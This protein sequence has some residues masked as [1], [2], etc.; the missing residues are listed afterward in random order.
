[1]KHCGVVT[2]RK[3]G[4][5]TPTEFPIFNPEYK[6]QQRRIYSDELPMAN[7]RVI[8]GSLSTFYDKPG[9]KLWNRL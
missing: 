1:M 9:V 6:Y 4:D 5:Y 7:W 8:K 3:C 2:D